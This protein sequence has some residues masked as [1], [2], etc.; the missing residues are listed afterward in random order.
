MPR[1]AASPGSVLPSLRPPLAGGRAGR[2]FDTDEGSDRRGARDADERTALAR[3]AF[4]AA[5]TVVLLAIV[6]LGSRGV[7]MSNE[8]RR[9]ASVTVPEIPNGVGEYM[10]LLGAFGVAATILL[11]ASVVAGSLVKRSHGGTEVVR[12]AIRP[13]AWATALMAFV[14]ASLIAIPIALLLWARGRGAVRP[15]SFRLGHLHA[16][17]TPVSPPPPWQG[18]TWGP[19]L[20][21]VGTVSV[22]ALVSFLAR[23]RRHEPAGPPASAR[24]AEAVRRSI[25]DIR[26]D[27]DPRHAVIA[28]YARMEE[29]LEDGGWPRRPSSAPFEYVEEALERMSVPPTPTRSL[30]ELFEI[31]RF[32]PRPVDDAMKE[33][34]VAALVEV[35]RALREPAP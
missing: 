23:R 30:T 33:R 24:L 32:S 1:R 31:A 35:D 22:A 29:S 18:W 16:S 17:L 13:S 7:H 9:P 34:A 21:V 28:A 14:M 25:D 20:L 10:I 26:R 4:L 6:A 27:P 8:A 5:L 11:L 12:R 2:G 15:P 19:A 3:T